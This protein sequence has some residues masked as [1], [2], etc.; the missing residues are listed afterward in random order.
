MK[1]RIALALAVFLIAVPTFAQKVTVDWD[2]EYDFDKAET[3]AWYHTKDHDIQDPLMEE[4]LRQAIEYQM[5]LGALRQVEENPDLWVTY[6]T[7]TKEQINVN[8]TSFGYG[9][10]PGWY[11]G[12]GGYYGGSMGGTSA[13]VTTYEVGTL[14]IDAWDAETKNMVWRGTATSTVYAKPEKMARTIQKAITKMASQWQK[15]KARS[16]KQ[17]EK[18]KE[19]AEK[20]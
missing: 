13:T 1:T 17:K 8:T 12:Y 9:Y 5:S 6:H 19:K 18:A 7:S 14:V 11:G 20:G 4:R 2:R 15:M 16:D 3:W 10:G